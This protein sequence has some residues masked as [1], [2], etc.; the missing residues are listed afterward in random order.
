M[1]KDIQFPEVKGVF[2]AIAR[3]KNLINQYEWFVYVNNSNLK[4]L[5]NVLITSKGYGELN[6]EQKTTSI[7]RHMIERL[8]GESFAVVEPIDPALFSLHNEFWV[9]Y[10]I[11]QQIYDKKFIFVPDSVSEE[12]I[13]FVEA[14]SLEGVV[15]G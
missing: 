12:N 3:K 2:L 14:L 7:L 6:G 11:N 4:P 15:H 9:S 10:Y 1:K 5:D 8:E 13:S